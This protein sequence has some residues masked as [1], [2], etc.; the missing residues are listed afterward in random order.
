VTEPDLCL[1]IRTQTVGSRGLRYP[2]TPIGTEAGVFAAVV[3]SEHD[4]GDGA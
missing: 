4:E 2:E 1:V 3:E